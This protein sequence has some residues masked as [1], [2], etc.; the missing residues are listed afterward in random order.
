M[1]NSKF[2]PENIQIFTNIHKSFKKE[3]ILSFTIGILF[4][5]TTVKTQVV[6]D[7]EANDWF[8]YRSEY[9]DLLKKKRLSEK[10]YQENKEKLLQ[11]TA[12]LKRE[13]ELLRARL[14]SLE[15]ELDSTR[16]SNLS[17]S[18]NTEK[19]LTEITE[20]LGE[21]ESIKEKYE[22]TLSQVREE[23]D[24]LARRL[25]KNQRKIDERNAALEVLDELEREKKILAEKYANLSKEYEALVNLRN[26]ELT[27]KSSVNEYDGLILSSNLEKL[28]TPQEIKALKEENLTL[29]NLVK[30]LTS[31]LEMVQKSE[32]DL[33]SKKLDE[34][35]EQL[36]AEYNRKLNQLTVQLARYREREQ[37]LTLENSKLKEQ[38]EKLSAKTRE[39]LEENLKD[40][41]GKGE[42]S[43]TQDAGRVIINI[44]DRIT[45]DTNNV[46][47]KRSGYSSLNKVISVLNKYRDRKIYVEGN[48]DNVPVR[49]GR[50]KDN[51]EI[52]THRALS[53]L[54]YIL[55]KT[56]LP[57][58]NFVAVGNGEFNPLKPNNTDS[59]K[60]MN[61]RVDI[62]LLP[63]LKT[64]NMEN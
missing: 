47:L 24:E 58:R 49:G 25:E 3:I 37:E 31:D 64:I 21:I 40:E 26:Q 57:E 35:A 44:Y 56:T 41:I 29:Q 12:A 52:S 45:F 5:T 14:S 38:V 27:Q 9:R 15:T 10:D 42:M 55:S 46:D 17:I 36:Q 32:K 48:T 34:Q 51:W 8:Y 62:V 13:N 30:K 11:E 54:R 20:R 19:K 33:L 43:V 6:S 63:N 2:F 53:V 28:P 50:Y 60:S 1:L 39:D 61:R 18:A 4:F 16:E 22:T 7:T 23:K 59:N